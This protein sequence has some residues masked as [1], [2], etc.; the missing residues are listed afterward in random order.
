MLAQIRPDS[1]IQTDTET[2]VWC[3]DPRNIPKL[4]LKPPVAR[5]YNL[6]VFLAEVFDMKFNSVS[7]LNRPNPLGTFVGHLVHVTC[8]SL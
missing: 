3:L 1:D 5:R 7:G 8:G 6:D 4:Y 2:E